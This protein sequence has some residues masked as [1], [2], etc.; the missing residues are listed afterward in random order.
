[1]N[2]KQSFVCQT[3]QRKPELGAELSNQASPPPDDGTLGAVFQSGGSAAIADNSA[4]KSA[5]SEQKA[6]A[7]E[8]VAGHPRQR[9]LFT[10][11]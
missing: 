1:M 2:E 10:F 5:A 6:S 8:N 11:L 9:F 3:L 7:E 4:A